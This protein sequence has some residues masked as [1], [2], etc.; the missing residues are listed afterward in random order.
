MK[1][2]MVSFFEGERAATAIECAILAASVS[3]VIIAVVQRIGAK[4]SGVFASVALR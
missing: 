1:N 2:L 4:L 3:L